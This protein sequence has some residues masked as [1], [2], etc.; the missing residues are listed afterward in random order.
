MR[1]LAVVLLILGIL[2]IAYGGFSYTKESTKAELGPIE[3]RVEEKERVNIPL[4]AG[5]AV[6]AVGAALLLKKS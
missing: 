5:V 3:L 2:A 4:W 1:I 6:T